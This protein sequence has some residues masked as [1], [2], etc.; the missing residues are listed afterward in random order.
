MDAGLKGYLVNAVHQW[1]VDQGQTPQIMVDALWAGVQ[2]PPG[3]TQDD[4][5]VLNIH[6]QA[7]SG[8]EMSAGELRFSARFGGQPHVIIVPLHAVLAVFARESGE[9]MS[10]P[11][12]DPDSPDPDR[13]E[14]DA[15]PSDDAPPAPGPRLRVI[16]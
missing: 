11:R 1:A 14:P 10:F 12:P 13:P 9:G 6:P 2:V 8:F 3:F 16:K 15:T 5:I 7:I 4:R